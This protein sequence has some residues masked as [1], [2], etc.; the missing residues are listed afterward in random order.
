MMGMACID[1]TTEGLESR[2]FARSFIVVD[3]LSNKRVAVACADIWSCTQ[4]VKTEV[5]HRLVK[6]F[7]NE[8]Y[9]I[10]NVLICG[11][12]THSGPG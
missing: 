2:L 7:G 12:H 6:I 9:T 1:Q 11:T 5:V 8:L 3:P 4:A 10:D